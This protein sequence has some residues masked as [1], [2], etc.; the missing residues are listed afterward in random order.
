[1]RKK[2]DIPY[3][4]KLLSMFY[5]VKTLKKN[6]GGAYP[7][8]YYRD[9]LSSTTSCRAKEKVFMDLY[10]VNLT[11]CIAFLHTCIHPR[12]NML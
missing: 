12:D 8:M 11:T 7:H 10:S 9:H 6:S 1:M 5:S 4:E 3:S 2:E